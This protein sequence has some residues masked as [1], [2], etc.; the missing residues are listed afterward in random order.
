MRFYKILRQLTAIML[1]MMLPLTAN[2]G[3]FRVKKVLKKAAP[4]AIVV[5]AVAVAGPAGAASVSLMSTTMYGAAAG[6]VC[7]AGKQVC[8]NIRNG[9]KIDLKKTIKGAA[10]GGAAGAL[11]GCV[12]GGVTST[13]ELGTLATATFSGACAGATYS[14]ASYAG[15]QIANREKFDLDNFVKEVEFGASVG[16]IVGLGTATVTILYKE[17]FAGLV[18][19]SKLTLKSVTINSAGIGG[20]IAGLLSFGSGKDDNGGKERPIRF[21]SDTG[22]G[23]DLLPG[24]ISEKEILSMQAHELDEYLATAHHYDEDSELS[25]LVDSYVSEIKPELKIEADGF[26]IEDE[27]GQAVEIREQIKDQLETLTASDS[28]LKHLKDSFEKLSG[29]DKEWIAENTGIEEAYP[30]DW[31]PMV[32][33]GKIAIVYGA[34]TIGKLAAKAA[35]NK[36]NI[37]FLKQIIKE[38]VG[39]I[40]IGSKK[41]GSAAG[42]AKKYTNPGHHDPS[43]RGANGYNKTKSVLPKE[44]ESLWKNS[45]SDPSNVN[46]RWTKVGE[47]KKATYHRFQSSNDGTWHWN[48][49]TN[50]V[51]QTGESRA[52]PMSKVPAQIKRM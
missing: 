50:G 51:T 52:I 28:N 8:R 32:M 30:E 2:A 9:E 16:A 39:A 25:K 19:G 11:A 31:L 37:S 7:G 23:V 4:I 42:K 24:Y 20:G 21:N 1:I 36:D 49:S 35:K 47:G 26:T 43:V 6:A 44:H 13:F 38:E 29:D 33:L 17:G 12:G 41:T 45:V 40:N 27:S 18:Q 34:K 3:R 14:G 22:P 5:V 48:G 15:T 10:V 46:T